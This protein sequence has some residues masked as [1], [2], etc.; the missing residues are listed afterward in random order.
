MDMW[1]EIKP[2]FLEYDVHKKTKTLFMARERKLGLFLAQVRME[3]HLSLHVQEERN[4]WLDNSE[5]TLATCKQT[6]FFLCTH[7]T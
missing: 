2:S 1:E 4:V 6:I 7:Y 3:T 5:A